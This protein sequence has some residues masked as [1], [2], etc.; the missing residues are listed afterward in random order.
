MRAVGYERYGPPEVLAV[1]DVPTPTAEAGQVLV[2]VVATGVN[3][4]DWECLVGSPAYAR[5]GGLRRPARPVL[6][7]DIAG[8][9]AALGP[10]VTGFAVGDEVYADNLGRK[11]GFAE[12]ALVPVSALARKPEG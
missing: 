7:S 1:R 4:S 12:F 10:G 8:R 3:L 6:G 9:V 5:I 2:E 11:G